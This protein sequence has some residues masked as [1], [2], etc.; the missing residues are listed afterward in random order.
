MDIFIQ[1]LKNRIKKGLP[2]DK[3]HQHLMPDKRLSVRNL[4]ASNKEY[5]SSAIGIIL[6]PKN[7]RLHSLLIQRTTYNGSHSGQVSFPGGK[8][9]PSDSNLEFTA[10]RECFEEVK[11]PLQS[12]ELIG[13]LS[14]IYIP[15]SN[16][17]VKPFV[18]YAKN[19]PD[20]YPEERE[21]EHLIYFDLEILLNDNIQKKGIVQVS[22]GVRQKNI[23]YFDIEQK[24]VW[25]ATAMILSELKEILKTID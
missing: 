9:D 14:D 16:F 22:K 5:R 12:G 21:V 18:F 7:N 10:R 25:G 20:F 4:I 8:M 13:E 19:E 15:V 3:A 1:Q 17:M 24:I 2:G 6:F 11:L 23:P